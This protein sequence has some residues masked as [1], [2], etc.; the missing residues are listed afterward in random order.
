MIIKVLITCV[1]GGLSPQLLRYI[2]ENKNFKVITFGVDRNINASGKYFSDY[3]YKVSSGNSKKFIFEIKKIV[4]ENKI[5]LVVPGSDE[6]ALNLAKNRKLIENRYTKI[7]CISYKKLKILSNKE[8]T[9]NFL[10][11]NNIDVPEFSVAK[12]K[13]QLEKNIKYY[14]KKYGSLVIKPS[15]S[16]GGRNVFIIKKNYNNVQYRNNG[17]EIMIGLNIFK[18]NFNK[19]KINFYP[20]IAMEKLNAPSYDFDMVCKN[21][22]LITGISRRRI[23]PSVPN[24]GHIIEENEQIFQLGKKV[25]KLFKLDWLYDCDFMLDNK[26]NPKIIEINPRMSGSV[27]VSMCAG[28]N[29][30]DDLFKI[31]FNK[32]LSKKKFRKETKVLPSISLYKLKS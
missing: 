1:G 12:N 6:D 21:G 32:K 10:K 2:K 11:N 29:L 9:Y 18:K 13:L 28:Y 19:L 25:A 24:D 16:R 8:K 27:A 23:N 17:R 4:V 20:I 22:E 14:I 31:Y 26:N 3:F 5:N 15:K 30:F 7:A